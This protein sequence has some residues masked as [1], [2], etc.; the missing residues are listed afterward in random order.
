MII[1]DKRRVTRAAFWGVLAYC[2]ISLAARFFAEAISGAGSVVDAPPTAILLLG[3][4]KAQLAAIAL[5]TAAGYVLPL[6]FGRPNEDSVGRAFLLAPVVGV[7]F[8]GLR[9]EY[10]FNL[11][12]WSGVQFGFLAAAIIPPREDKKKPTP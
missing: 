7:I 9:D 5:A 11:D 10:G 1:I 2:A 6:S 4:A 3:N 12:F 8:M